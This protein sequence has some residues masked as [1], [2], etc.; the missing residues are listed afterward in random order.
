M[1]TGKLSSGLR[2]SAMI[3]AIA[4]LFFRVVYCVCYALF[5][6]SFT[7]AFANVFG[8]LL[9]PGFAI[10]VLVYC[11]GVCDK[12]SGKMFLGVGLSLYVTKYVIAIVG[13]IIS[14]GVDR[15]FEMYF[16]N[17]AVALE[18]LLAFLSMAAIAVFAVWI[19]M[20]ARKRV[21]PIIALSAF[22][23]PFMYHLPG[24][25]SGIVR[26]ISDWTAY[27]LPSLSISSYLF[28]ILSEIAIILV[29]IGEIKRAGSRIPK[30]PVYTAPVQQTP[31]YT[32]PVQQTPVYTAPVQQTPV[33]TAPVQQTPAQQKSENDAKLEVLQKLF[34]AGTITEEEYRKELIDLIS[35][36]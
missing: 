10:I 12:R 5:E 17:E 29:I 15:Y 4:A 11:L 20:G 24:E 18:N 31:V 28:S 19:F 6:N 7:S 34:E 26:V 21:L 33:Y 3:I 32:A 36:K 16:R 13:G 9:F 1:T 23:L 22:S 8:D 14:Y 25:I 30:K 2:I 35:G 27:Y